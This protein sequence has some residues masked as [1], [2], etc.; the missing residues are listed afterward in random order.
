[1]SHIVTWVTFINILYKDI[2]VE[3][4]E[5]TAHDRSKLRTAHSISAPCNDT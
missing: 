4:F 5:V 3:C 1:M 2:V